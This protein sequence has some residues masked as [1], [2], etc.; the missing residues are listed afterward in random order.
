METRQGRHAFTF[1]T[2]RPAYIYIIGGL[3][4]IKSQLCRLHN[5]DV[6]IALFCFRFPPPDDD[7]IPP[8]PVA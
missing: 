2:V 3:G 4:P 1:T 5:V 7:T 6:C 8:S